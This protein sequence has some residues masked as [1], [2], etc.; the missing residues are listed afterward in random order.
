MR[1]TNR[2]DSSKATTFWDILTWKWGK[3]SP[4][5]TKPSQVQFQ[6]DASFLET[7]DDFICWLSHAGF[8]IQLS[9]KRFLIDPVFG[10]IPFYKRRIAFPYPPELLGQ[11]D[12]ILISHTH[13]DHMDMPSIKQ[14]LP[15]RPQF[16]LPLGMESYIRKLDRQATVITL[17]WYQTHTIDEELKIHLVPA[18]HWGRRTPFDTNQALWGGFII[19]SSHHSIY[20]AGDTAYDHHFKA[21]GERY[22]LDYALLPIGAYNPDFIMKHHHLNPDEAYQAFQDLNAATMIPMHYGT[23]KLTDEPINE[24]EAWLDRLQEQYGEK[25]YKPEFDNS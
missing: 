24:P 22:A 16:I 7:D 1:F 4:R 15:H 3:K 23:F 9:G 25:I 2:F 8:L 10:D 5:D 14:I 20:F 11:I 13:Y 18:K 19:E 12:Y 17:D 6:N 21:I